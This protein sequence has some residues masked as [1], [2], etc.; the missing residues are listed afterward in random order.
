MQPTC[1]CCSI[2]WCVCQSQVLPYACSNGQKAVVYRTVNA[3]A[4]DR[5]IW[6]FAD[7]PHLMKTA[8]NCLY[9]SSPGKSTRCM[10]NDGEYLLWQHISTSVNED[11]DNGLCSNLSCEHTELTSYSVMN[12]RLAAQVLSETTGKILKEYH[13]PDMHST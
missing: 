6:L 7:V 13:S 2:R 5:F 4:P 8:R 1:D 12:V 10:W 3:Y 9:Y 11:A